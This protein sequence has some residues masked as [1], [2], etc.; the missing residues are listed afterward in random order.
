MYEMILSRRRLMI[1]TGAFMLTGCRG[2]QEESAAQQ[3]VAEGLGVWSSAPSLPDMMRGCWA[4]NTAILG[5]KA[6]C[7]M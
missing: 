4:A 1:G 2:L 6:S 7:E 3:T 5:G